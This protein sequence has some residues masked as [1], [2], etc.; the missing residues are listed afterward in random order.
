MGE[1]YSTLSK[2][3]EFKKIQISKFEIIILILN[4]IFL[5]GPGSFNQS[6]FKNLSPPMQAL[7]SSSSLHV[8]SYFSSLFFPKIRNNGG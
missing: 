6:R 3:F 7:N 1:I 4:L 5:F 8:L 2:K